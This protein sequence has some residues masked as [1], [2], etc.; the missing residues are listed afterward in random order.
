MAQGEQGEIALSG[1][2]VFRGYGPP[3]ATPERSSFHATWFRT[4]DLGFVDEEGYL[5]VTGRLGERINRGGEKIAPRAIEAALREHP[6]VE[7]ALCFPI[8]DP[9]LGEEIGA[10][11]KTPGGGVVDARELRRFA[12]TRLAPTRV[13]RFF[14][15]R[16][17]L[18]QP[19]SGK[20]NRRALAEELGL[21][22]DSREAH[23]VS[24]GAGTRDALRE[25]WQDQLGLER[26][27]RDDDRFFD[28]GGTSLGLV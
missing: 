13:P 14:W 28:L 1:A 9:S 17:Q 18:P 12:A 6:Q 25:I 20:L 24:P 19:A 2:N 10:L 22:P 7:E 8:P 26:A 21:L 16:E 5:H 4:G 15:F 23:D 11:I 3:G 27:T